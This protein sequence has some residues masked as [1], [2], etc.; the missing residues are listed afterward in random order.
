MKVEKE[1]WSWKKGGGNNKVRKE[2]KEL[3]R[4]TGKLSG[5]AKGSG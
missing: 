1:M 3:G 4:E 2:R 5:R